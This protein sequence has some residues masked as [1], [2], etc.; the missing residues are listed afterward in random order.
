MKQRNNAHT[1]AH[2]H[3]LDS[4]INMPI[5]S[6]PK[7]TPIREEPA[8]RE[9]IACAR[10]MDVAVACGMAVFGGAVGFGAGERMCCVHDCVSSCVAARRRTLLKHKRNA[11]MSP[12]VIVLGMVV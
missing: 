6:K 9:V 2:T 11:Q 12:A 3:T 1:H 4:Q 7:F 8:F 5:L 10:V